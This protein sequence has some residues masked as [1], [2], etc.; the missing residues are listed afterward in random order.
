MVVSAFLESINGL[1]SDPS[2]A[3]S[4]I[5][6]VCDNLVSV[7]FYETA[8]PYNKPVYIK[9][10]SNL[11]IKRGLL[12][13]DGAEGLRAGRIQANTPFPAYAG[14]QFGPDFPPG[15]ADTIIY[16][17]VFNSWFDIGA[18]IP[19][20]IARPFIELRL[21]AVSGWYDARNIPDLYEGHPFAARL[22]LDIEAVEYPL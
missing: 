1:I 16:L 8:A 18:V 11:L 5:D 3:G 19:A 9:K 12:T 7:N 14:L 2:E 6:L 20:Q 13:F 17:P 21:S 22:S 15:S 4:A 10:D